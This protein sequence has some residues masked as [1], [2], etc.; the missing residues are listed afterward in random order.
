MR[1]FTEQEKQEIRKIIGKYPDL[2]EELCN[3]S[4][5]DFGKVCEAVKMRKVL[6]NQ[7]LPCKE[8]MDSV[9]LIYDIY[10]GYG[11]HYTM[12]QAFI[13]GRIQGVRAER[14]RRKAR[15]N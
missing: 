14:A 15:A 10:S 13:Y 7:Y 9:D 3:L 4:V 11:I 12:M 1:S 5:E 8:D 2:C 6:K